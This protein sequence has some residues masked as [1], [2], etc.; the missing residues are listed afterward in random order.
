MSQT[1]PA[2]RI[3]L[4]DN[5]VE[6]ELMEK[7]RRFPTALLSDA[8]FKL[9]TLDYRIK[10][11]WQA[12]YALCGPA[13]TVRVRP[14]DNAMCVKAI[15]L[16]KPGD[17]IVVQGHWDTTHS[18]WGGIMSLLAKKKGVAGLVTDGL[19]RDTA[20]MRDADFPVWARGTTPIAPCRNVPPGQIGTQ[21]VCGN[22]AINSG[23]VMVADEDGAV[24]VPR[25][26]ISDVIAAAEAREAKE[27]KWIEQ[28]GRGE[29]ILV[30]A[31]NELLEQNG[32]TIIDMKRAGS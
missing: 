20:Q 6:P 23:D 27:D 4:R 18:I 25:N 13:L 15:E 31:V 7:I 5:H 3:E 11:V 2:F 28:I 16:A 10:P 29:M 24:V 21:I 26:E 32:C 9:N 17:V 30:D 19:V 14:G 1:L 8:M 22:T 12:P